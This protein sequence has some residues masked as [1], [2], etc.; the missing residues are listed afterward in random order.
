MADEPSSPPGREGAERGVLCARCEHVNPPGQTQCERCAAPLFTPCPHCGQPTQR[1]FLR[2]QHCHHR[3]GRTDAERRRRGR[4]RGRNLRRKLAWLL[5][6][7][8]GA[9]FGLRLIWSAL[10]WL[11]SRGAE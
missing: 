9:I 7:A 6:G 3:I 8:I 5:L 4:G 10:S 2:C 1:V 11:N